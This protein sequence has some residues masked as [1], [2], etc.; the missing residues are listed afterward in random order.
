MQGLGIDS[1]FNDAEICN[2]VGVYA[3]IA[4]TQDTISFDTESSRQLLL[5]SNQDIQI[6]TSNKRVYLHNGLPTAAKLTVKDIA[7]KSIFTSTIAQSINTYDLSNFADGIYFV[8]V[9]NS[10][11]ERIKNIKLVLSN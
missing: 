5:N 2:A 9:F 3:R 11:N 10:S 4:N 6:F 7:G 8:E 1:D